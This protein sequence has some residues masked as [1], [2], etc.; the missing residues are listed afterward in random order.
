[1]MQAH[2]QLSSRTL[3]AVMMWAASSSVTNR[4]SVSR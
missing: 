3:D 1:M 4:Q 2:R